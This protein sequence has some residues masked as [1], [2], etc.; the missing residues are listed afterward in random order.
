MA[1]G[2]STTEQSIGKEPC[3]CTS[4]VKKS[5][6][7]PYSLEDQPWISLRDK[8]EQCP[9]QLHANIEQEWFENDY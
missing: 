3:S 5:A 4:K 6:Y 1:I 9:S 7:I 2:T 8:L